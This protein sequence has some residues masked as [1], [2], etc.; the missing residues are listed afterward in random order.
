MIKFYCDFCGGEERQESL[1]S[2]IFFDEAI[3]F[4]AANPKPQQKQ[5]QKMICT[6]CREKV[7][8]ALVKN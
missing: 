2:L 4:S 1:G 8:K 3:D 6:K 5:T 7:E